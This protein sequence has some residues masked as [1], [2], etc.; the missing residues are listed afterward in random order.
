MVG[1]HR[2]TITVADVFCSELVAMLECWN[3][4]QRS[5]SVRVQLFF[6]NPDICFLNPITSTLHP[7][8]GSI[9][10]SHR[11]CQTSWWRAQLCSP[12]LSGVF[13]PHPKP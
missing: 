4:C 12:S 7:E 8:Q 2:R 9:G 10:V 6:Q 5:C 1:H 3:L 11:V 13:S